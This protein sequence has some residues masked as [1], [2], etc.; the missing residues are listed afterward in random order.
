MAATLARAIWT[1]GCGHGCPASGSFGSRGD[2]NTSLTGA[3]RQR[4]GARAGAAVLGGAAGRRVHR[5]VRDSRALLAG[6]GV[7]G[8]SAEEPRTRWVT[9]LV[10]AET[11]GERRALA[12]TVAGQL[13]IASALHQLSIHDAS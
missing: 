12:P 1:R 5:V 7:P 6:R 3:V 9:S 2:R 8:V 13:V 11:R 10:A 4:P